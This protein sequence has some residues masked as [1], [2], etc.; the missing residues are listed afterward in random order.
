ME[1]RLV[2]RGKLQCRALLPMTKC[3]GK[4]AGFL[5]SRLRKRKA[6]TAQGH[7]SKLH[8]PFPTSFVPIN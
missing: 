8:K 7:H 5:V 4:E 1:D 6:T 2:I 3:G